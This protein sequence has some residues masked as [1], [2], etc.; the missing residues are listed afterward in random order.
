MAIDG[1]ESYLVRVSRPAMACQFE[2]CLCAG[3]YPQGTEAALEALDQVEQ[4]ED[5]L[6]VFRPQSE[7]NQINAAAAERA[8]AVK[9]RLFA[10]LQLAMHVSRETGGAYDITAGPLWE[11]WGFAR[12]AGAVPEIE[13]LDEA[14]SLVGAH[15]VE[16]DAASHSVRFLTPGVRL[17]LGSVG[18]G[19]AVDRCGETLLRR[20]IEDF[21]VHGGSSSVFAHGSSTPP[22]DSSSVRP[23]GWIVGL[24]D[25]LRPQQRLR[26]LRLCD[27]ALGTSGAQFQS[28]RHRGRRYGHILDPRT[29]WPAEGVLSA[30]AIAP[31]AA[32]ADILSTAFYVLGPEAALAYCRQHKGIAAIILSPASRGGGLEVHSTGLDDAL[33]NV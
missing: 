19:F 21:L 27:R 4:L 16:L 10:L 8:V 20:G 31:S 12:R 14:R 11:A 22:A 29:G 6:S 7:L 17:N 15:L 18:K 3:Q 5:Q 13:R 23:E 25:P 32:L 28:F 9:P 30:T 2:I 33:G 26:Q 24:R 1:G